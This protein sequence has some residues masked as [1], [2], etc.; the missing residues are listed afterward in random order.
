MLQYYFAL[1]QFRLIKWSFFIHSATPY[2]HPSI[3]SRT[4][5]KFSDCS[6]SLL[7]LHEKS[8]FFYLVIMKDCR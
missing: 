4:E 5:P 8:T 6:R 2:I 1:R 7:L 3:D